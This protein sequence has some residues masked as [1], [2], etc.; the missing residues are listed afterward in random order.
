VPHDR[1]QAEEI[2]LIEDPARGECVPERVGRA[3]RSLDA[4]HPQRG[5]VFL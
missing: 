2:A 3:P 4:G 5:Q 1:L